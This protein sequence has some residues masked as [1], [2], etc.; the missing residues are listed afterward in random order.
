MKVIAFYTPEYK[1]EAKD[2]TFSCRAAGL[3]YFVREVPNQGSWRLNVGM[4]PAFIK[5]ALR[6]FEEDV[7]WV[8]ID[9]RFKR[10]WDLDLCKDFDFAAWFIPH[11]VMR[12]GVPFGKESGNDG[13]ASGTMWFNNSLYAIEFLRRWV[14][15]EDGQYRWGQQVLGE[16]WHSNRPGDLRTFRLPHEYCKVFD[17]DWI[18]RDHEPV[19]IEHYQAS[20][21]LRSRIKSISK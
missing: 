5:K 6:V 19:V 8:D 2:W 16:L 17:R 14:E 1:A 4:K 18:E 11:K 7:L 12:S 21:R 9:G 20:R 13:I 3:D 10:D 15:L